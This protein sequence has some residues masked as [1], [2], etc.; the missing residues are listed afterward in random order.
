MYLALAMAAEDPRA[1]KFDQRI[2]WVL[3]LPVIVTL[4]L[5]LFT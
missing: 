2:L 5:Y 1:G 4:V 3:L